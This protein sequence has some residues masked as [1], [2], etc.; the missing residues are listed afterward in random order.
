MKKGHED[1]LNIL[2]CNDDGIDAQG[3]RSLVSSLA[4]VANVYVSA[5]HAQRSASGHAITLGRSFDLKR[6]KVEGAIEAIQTT[7]TPADCVKMG[8]RYFEF[9][10]VDMDIVF[11]GI[12][13]GSNLGT[14]TLY[15]GTVS[16]A[17]EG[18]LCGKPSIAISVGSHNPKHGF[19]YA[20]K[21]ALHVLKMS[22]AHLESTM[23]LNVNIPDIPAKDIKGLVVTKLGLREYEGFFKPSTVQEG[24]LTVQYG[25]IPVVYNSKNREIDVLADQ[26]GYATLTPL[27][28][29]LTW[30]DMLNDVKEWGLE[31]DE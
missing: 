2:V 29:D 28:F 15:S 9:R 7:G 19:D 10:G 25:G 6:V 22:Y 5:P 16:A 13:H 20:A 27:H 11:S 3:I 14:D 1:R 26:Q 18:S 4:T 8:L 30:Q 23:T 31:Y 24:H 12:N 21:L 17:L